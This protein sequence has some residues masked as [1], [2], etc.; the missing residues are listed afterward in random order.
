MFEVIAS[1]VFEAWLDSLDRKT[2]ALVVARLDKVRRGLFGDVEPVG[3]GI[4]E[5]RM[6]EGPGYRI[7]FKKTGKTIVFLLTG[8][9]KATQKNDIA[10]AKELA[11]SLK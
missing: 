3:N 2:T 6:H 1:D 8:G 4:S 5:L 9:S 7:Y 10:Y 11:K